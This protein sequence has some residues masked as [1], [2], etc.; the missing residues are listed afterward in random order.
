MS[1]P[2]PGARVH[3]VYDR[4]QTPFQ[5]LSAPV[6]PRACARLQGWL[7]LGAWVCGDLAAGRA[8]HTA[9]IPL[10]LGLARL[11]SRRARRFIAQAA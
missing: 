3:R 10:L 2:D 9:E 1:R 8:A 6:L 5:R 4:A 7:H 11:R